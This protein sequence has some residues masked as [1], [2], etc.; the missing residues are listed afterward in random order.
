M[1]LF[2]I[3]KLRYAGAIIVLS[4]IGTGNGEM[5]F[6]IA[7][8]AVGAGER[9]IGTAEAT[10]KTTKKAAEISQDINGKFDKAKKTLANGAKPG[11]YK[12]LDNGTN[13]ARWCSRSIDVIINDKKAPLGARADFEKAM[14]KAGKTVG[15]TFNI[16]GSTDIIPDTNYYQR[17]GTPYPPV[18]IAWAYASESNIIKASQSGATV[19]NPIESDDSAR[20]VTGAI[21]LNIDHDVLYKPGFGSGM[22]RGN[23]YLHELG[24]L[25]GLDHVGSNKELMN[26]SID[27]DTPNGYASGDTHGLL[28]LR[29]RE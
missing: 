8:S 9:I 3:F 29:C 17:A 4:L 5:V 25:V 27:K 23:L 12:F 16:I 26:S 11:E 13:V 20:Y 18:A 7:R 15:I 1:W 28:K 6:T 10:Y 2:R 14:L 21:V 22:S 24:H 19:V